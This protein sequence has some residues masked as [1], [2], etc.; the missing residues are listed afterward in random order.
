MFPK[1]RKWVCVTLFL[2]A[3]L[4]AAEDD[5]EAGHH[6][7]IEAADCNYL[8]PLHQRDERG[9]EGQPV[10][11]FRCARGRARTSTRDSRWLPRG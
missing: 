2:T 9:H 4:M 11:T 7:Q 8:V 10:E 5:R 3:P 1:L 6:W